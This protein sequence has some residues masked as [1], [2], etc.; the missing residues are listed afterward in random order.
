MSESILLILTNIVTG[1]A[2]WF[3]GK[4]R[5]NAETDNQILHNLELSI[6]LYREIIEDLKK[7]I[8]SLNV[9]VQDLELKV[10]NLHKENKKLKLKTDAESKT[11]R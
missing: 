1:V 7:Q 4:K 3:V 8:E 11:K 6:N 9:K 2:A 5:A 10:D